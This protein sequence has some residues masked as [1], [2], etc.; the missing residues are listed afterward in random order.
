M[1]PLRVKLK[2]FLCYK[3]EQEISFDGASLWMLAGLN[4]SGKSTVFDAV[5]YAL[6]GH[7]RG[8]SQD[9]QELINKDSD[10]TAVEFDF[11]LDG[12]RFQAY[13]TVQLTKQG[14]SKGTQQIFRRQPDGSR[15]AVPGTNLKSGFDAWVQEN[16]GLSYETFTSSVLLLQGK[17]D[18]LLDSTAKGRHEVLAGIVDLER[19]KRLHQRADEE[20]KGHEATI[21]SLQNRLA[22]LPEVSAA[23]LA[24]AD[25]NITTADAARQS[26][27]AEVERLQGLEFQARQWADLQGRLEAARLRWQQ[28]EQLLGDAPAIE[29]DVDRLRELREVLP[30]LQTVH[31]QHSQLR[32][33][34]LKSKELAGQKQKLEAKL[35]QQ[36]LG[37]A[38]AGRKRAELQESIS[39][40]ELRHRDLAAR[41]RQAATQLVK[42]RQYEGQES[43]LARLRRELAGLPPDPA[44]VLRQAQEAHDGLA[45]LAHAVP[46][47]ARLHAQREELKQAGP[48][49]QAARQAQQAVQA[50]GEQ[51]AAELERLRPRLEEA[52]R[53]RE[54][55]DAEATRA[56]T[57]LEQARHQ[58][59]DLNQL[60][61]AKVCR[62]C[63]QALTAQHVREE[64]RRREKEVAQ[65]EKA[66]QQAAAGQ[67]TAQKSELDLRQQFTRLDK[68]LQEA[69]EEF[70]EQRT[71][72]DQARKDVE[73][74][75]QE[76]GLAHHELAEPFRGRVCA[77]PPADWLE[78][79]YPTAADLA[80]ARRQAAGLDGLR[81]NLR[82][83]EQLL[84]Q[85]NTLKG[86]EATALQALARLQGELP[87]DREAVR[88]E[89]VRLE[90]EEQALDRDLTARRAEAVATQEQLDRLTREREQTNQQL[91]SLQAKLSTEEATR[92]LCRQSLE[93]A[94]KE[95]PSAWQALADRAGLA[96]LNNW[97]N[98]RDEL[99]RKQTDERGRQLQQARLG[100]EVL[101]HE[102]DELERQQEQY[103]AEARQDPSRL[104]AQVQEAR[105]VQ[106]ARDNDLV[107]ARQHKAQLE[108]FRRQRDQLEQEAREAEKTLAHARL[109]ADLLGRDRL[110]L[111]LVRQA[112]R[113]V[114]DYANA[115]LDRLSGGQLYLRL[116]GEAGGDGNAAK[117]LELEAHNR[118][119]GDRPINVAFLSGSQK[120]RVAVSLALGIG[121]YASRRHRPIESVII[122][123]GFGCLDKEGRQAMIH[124]MQNLRDQLKCILLVSHQEEFADAFADGYH[125]ELKDKT[126]RATRFQR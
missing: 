94:R 86:Q 47:L 24:E 14:K 69:R 48:R 46:L 4:G 3:E 97:S 71:R 78:T 85:W 67:Q 98:E 117:A 20:R 65:A 96:D 52:G 8:G 33:S 11:A 91:A 123:E 102:R 121:Q 17:A 6:F 95:L 108:T 16:I 107:H 64:K 56:I 13:R 50:R 38:Q 82:D 39:A 88:R 109:L 21:K 7:H 93:R 28:A 32:D 22:A 89:H 106:R 122:D 81:R 34:D 26:A 104:Q 40:D 1:I 84:V 101:R 2:G 29:R 113:Q 119:T 54:R 111:H 110:Q 103:P 57:L 112:E 9:A 83:A 42:L 37:L 118:S 80:D 23:A 12:Q 58:L 19:Y 66:Y 114:V 100:L 41:L 90:A 25:A 63:G 77:T 99:V 87:A 15:E 62:H 10:R 120:F 126:T 59:D 18:R 30:R 43:D 55:A 53:A 70:R 116:C 60:F 35:H 105:Q 51:R 31:H 73:R 5:T 27:Q 92:Q 68:Q 61:G 125:F 49:E 44:A 45:G 76:C 75:Q 72:A 36:D 74:L 79:S 124:E 115:V